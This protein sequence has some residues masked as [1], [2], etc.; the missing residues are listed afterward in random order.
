MRRHPH[1]QPEHVTRLARRAQPEVLLPERAQQR[2]VPVLDQLGRAADVY[3]LVRVLDVEDCQA[4]PWVPGQILAFWRVAVVEKSTKSPSLT[5]Q[6]IEVCGPP[7][8]FS[9][10]TVATFL[11]SSSLRVSWSNLAAT[12]SPFY[13]A[14]LSSPFACNR[15]ER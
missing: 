14:T 15:C 12:A 11:P 6:T 7:S 8:G 5:I 2:L 9:V 10:A 13:L 3:G 4:D 1:D